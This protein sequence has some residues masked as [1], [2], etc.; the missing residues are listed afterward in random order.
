MKL[1]LCGNNT[2]TNF[3]GAQR[4][5]KNNVLTKLRNLWSRNVLGIGCGTHVIHNFV[6]TSCDILPIEI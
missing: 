6:Q 1:S 5:G 3:G 4:G 2:N